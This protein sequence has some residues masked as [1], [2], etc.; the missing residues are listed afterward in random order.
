MAAPRSIATSSEWRAKGTVDEATGKG[1]FGICWCDHYMRGGRLDMIDGQVRVKSVISNH[2][3]PMRQKRPRR[4]WS[5]RRE[6]RASI[7]TSG[8]G[9]GSYPRRKGVW[10]ILPAP[11]RQLLL[12][13]SL[14]CLE[15]R[16]SILRTHATVKSLRYRGTN[17]GYWH[18][19]SAKSTLGDWWVRGT[20]LPSFW[21]WPG[22]GGSPVPPYCVHRRFLNGTRQI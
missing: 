4:R 17:L 9:T 18:P 6:G 15:F 1:E 3:P 19:S 10:M 14:L 22:H 12:P 20:R 7:I 5:T 13:V 21:P 8:I 11:A 16:L 2:T